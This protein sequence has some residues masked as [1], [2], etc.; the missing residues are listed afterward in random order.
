MRQIKK[1]SIVL[2]AWT[3]LL[4]IA[5]GG[6]RSMDDSH[7][8][9]II[10]KMQAVMEQ[11][12]EASKEQEIFTI[13]LEANK[14]LISKQLT[15]D[16]V[17]KWEIQMTESMINNISTQIYLDWMI[18]VNKGEKKNIMTPAFF[19]KLK[20]KNMD[21]VYILKNK[22]GEVLTQITMNPPN[23]QELED[24]YAFEWNEN[25]IKPSTVVKG[26]IVD[27][28]DGKTYKTVK[29]GKQTWMAENLNFKAGNS[30][31]Y[32]N[33]ESSCEEY[34]R[35]YTWADAMD[36]A[37]VFSTNGKG[38]GDE[39]NCSPTYPVRG[40]CPQNWHLPTLAEFDSLKVAVGGRSIAGTNLKSA[41]GWNNEGNGTD[42]YGFSAL[43]SGNR[44]FGLG[45]F[46][47]KGSRAFFWSATERSE[48]DVFQMF[49]ISD[50]QEIG[51]NE[52]KSASLSVRCVMD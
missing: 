40:I 47:H 45:S 28:R 50:N 27:D 42:A 39:N 10:E 7:F 26:T 37:A 33:Q 25:A 31:C 24:L 8:A 44:V 35:L 11:K 29:I 9:L 30:S 17:S 41:S 2:L 15:K 38:C 34:G 20:E 36:S 22:N 48:K 52:I 13:S 18:S 12:N 51:A 4:I 16:N 32:D 43:P 5:C 3:S 14:L 46:W 23:M 19:S 1:A 49:L 21:I 6:S